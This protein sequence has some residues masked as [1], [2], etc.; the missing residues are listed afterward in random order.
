MPA[1]NWG[2]AIFSTLRIL[3]DDIAGILLHHKEKQVYF[4]IVT[5]NKHT[6]SDK[7]N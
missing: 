7:F 3:I 4:I 6:I 2:V 5:N 1:H